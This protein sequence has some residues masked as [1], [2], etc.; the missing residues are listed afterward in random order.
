M[1]VAV[2]AYD[3]Y[4]WLTPTFMHFYKKNWSDNPYKTDFV[5]TSGLSWADYMLTFIDSLSDEPFL[6]ILNDYII[7]R[8]VD[9]AIV[10]RAENLCAGDIGCVRLNAHDDLSCHLCDMGIEGFKEY[11]LNKPYAVSLQISIWRKEFFL[12][13]LRKGETIW[14]TE[15][16]GS[17]RVATSNKKV[18]W[19]DRP[20]FSYVPHGYMQKGVIDANV[21]KWAKENW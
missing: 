20:A 6:L 1:K 9:T 8:H 2:F 15:L 18:L 13:F 19:S 5:V 4:E 7:N 17:K 21:E 10:K 12:E 11:P 14:M 16:E 3:K